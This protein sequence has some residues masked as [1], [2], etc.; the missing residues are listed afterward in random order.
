MY[1]VLLRLRRILVL[2]DSVIFKVLPL[3][4]NRRKIPFKSGSCSRMKG[5]VN[6]LRNSGLGNSKTESKCFSGGCW[7]KSDY[8]KNLLFSKLESFMGSAFFGH[9]FPVLFVRPRKHVE[10]VNASG[11]VSSWAVVKDFQSIW[12]CPMV[13]HPANSMGVGLPVVTS[14]HDLS[15]SFPIC[16]PLPKPAA[17]RLCALFNLGPKP[18]KNGWRESLRDEKR[19]SSVSVF[20]KL[21]HNLLDRALG[22][23]TPGYFL[24]CGSPILTPTS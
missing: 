13:N 3:V 4:S 10:R 21:A 16:C 15:V 14:N 17:I 9:I 23:Q 24:F 20:G 11:V 2:S 7:P 5:S 1:F 22:L 12:D 19:E 18:F 6:D 8:L